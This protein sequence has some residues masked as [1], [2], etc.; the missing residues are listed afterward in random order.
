MQVAASI[1]YDW[2]GGNALDNWEKDTIVAE[3]EVVSSI[4]VRQ[5]RIDCAWCDKKHLVVVD[6]YCK[7][8]G[9]MLCSNCGMF[10]RWTVHHEG[11]V[12]HSK[13]ARPR[14]TEGVERHG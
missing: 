7:A 9:I 8:S 1:D 4:D 3:V 12:A 14:N 2:G 6:R 10:F 11:S 13:R 5:S